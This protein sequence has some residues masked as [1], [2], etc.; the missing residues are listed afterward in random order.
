MTA[1]SELEPEAPAESEPS[2]LLTIVLGIGS[3]FTASLL[4]ICIV[5]LILKKKK[6]PK[7]AP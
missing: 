3:V 1:D 4:V 2:E 6:Q 5:A 7:A